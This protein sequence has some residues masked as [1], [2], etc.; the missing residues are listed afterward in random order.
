MCCFIL[1][2][3][4]EARWGDSCW[5]WSVNKLKIKK[6]NQKKETVVTI[7]IKLMYLLKMFARYFIYSTKCPSRHNLNKKNVAKYGMTFINIHIYRNRFW[8][9]CK[10]EITLKMYMEIHGKGCVLICQYL[11]NLQMKYAAS[12][13]LASAVQGY[14]LMSGHLLM[15]D[16][17]IVLSLY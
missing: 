2:N 10:K 6:H 11:S 1:Y 3:D 4:H 16:W 7:K 12:Q 13:F 9:K 14:S 15:G 8:C 5:Q 17:S